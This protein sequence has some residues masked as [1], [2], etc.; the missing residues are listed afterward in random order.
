MKQETL[1]TIDH[2]KL[3]SKEMIS[4]SDELLHLPP[5][6]EVMGK[7]ERIDG[8]LV[9]LRCSK[10]VMILLP[11]ESIKRYRNILK[12]ESFVGI[13]K[14]NEDNGNG[15]NENFRIRAITN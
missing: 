5:W 12:I 13:I 10:E 1:S 6:V 7:L 8:K 11:S 3:S 15:G 9:T 4:Q 2:R 14:I